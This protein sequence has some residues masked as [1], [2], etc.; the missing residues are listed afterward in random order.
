MAEH[1]P[2]SRQLPIAAYKP[3]AAPIGDKPSDAVSVVSSAPATPPALVATPAAAAVP[4]APA[5]SLTAATPSPR[6]PSAVT[7]PTP[8]APSVTAS[9]EFKWLVAELES[10]TAGVIAKSVTVADVEDALVSV[11]APSSGL[12]SS[13]P[14]PAM[15]A[16]G[17]VRIAPPADWCGPGRESLLMAGR[18]GNAVPWPNLAVT[19]HEPAD[20]QLLC[21]GDSGPPA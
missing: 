2:P 4:P 17:R 15:A 8:I 13:L 7:I 16:V 1:E 3:S 10:E 5:P 9:E 21:G 20:L 14:L 11:M 18:T 6:V 12:S 19:L